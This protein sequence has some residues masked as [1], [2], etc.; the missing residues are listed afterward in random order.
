[1]EKSTGPSGPVRSSVECVVVILLFPIKNDCTEKSYA[2]IVAVLLSHRK[3]IN[4]SVMTDADC[5][6]IRHMSIKRKY[7]HTVTV[8]F[9]L[10]GINGNIVL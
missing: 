9:Q 5:S 4:V 8:S 2:T 1:V 7:V 6:S 3:L 10:H